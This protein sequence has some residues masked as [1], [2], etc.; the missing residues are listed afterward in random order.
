MVSNKKEGNSSKKSTSE[1][2][3]TGGSAQK[4]NT[5]SK[6][7]GKAT[8]H[9]K[10][11][12]AKTSHAK[13]S[14]TQ[15]KKPTSTET[16]VKKHKNTV[17]KKPGKSKEKK[18]IFGTVVLIIVALIAVGLIIFGVFQMINAPSSQQ[19]NGENPA[20]EN[21][22]DT[23]NLKIVEDPSC[24]SCKPG[25]IADKLKNNIISGLQYEKIDYKSKE[26][27]KF[28]NQLQLSQVPAFFFSEEIT[29]HPEW[30]SKLKSAFQKEEVEG[31]TY[32]M[33]NPALVQNKVVLGNIPVL[34]GT[35][36]IGDENANLTIFEFSDFE[37]PYCSIAAGNK[38]KIEA[39]KQKTG[40]SNYKAPIPNVYENYV[41]EGK[42]KIVY[43]NFP[44]H[45][46]SMQASLAALCANEQDEF[47][48]Y[49]KM[50]FNN[51]DEWT[52]NNQG[53]KLRGYAEELGL[54]TSKFN[55]CLE[56][57]TYKEQ[58]KREKQLG[59]RYGVSGTPSFF[60]EGEMLSGAQSYSTFKEIIEKN[61]NN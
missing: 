18:P 41:K 35:A 34:N 59:T 10:T 56:N 38:K 31:N 17:H 5:A 42:V 58:I 6:N 12:Q 13:G 48:N 50:L 21:N 24:N 57:E 23:V 8:S 45:S 30:E 46:N 37:C 7:T 14:K 28:V 39:F 61:L 20:G 44:T 51:V 29:N 27:Q 40:M 16:G 53:A 49:H 19:G 1:K 54:N 52:G 33:L 26:G 2:K 47:Y 43:Y 25:S 9:K 32:Y 15:T 60:I 11:T 36:I 4:K 3:T 22:K 55:S